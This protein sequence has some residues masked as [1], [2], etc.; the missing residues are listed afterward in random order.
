M[1]VL[2]VVEGTSKSST[3]PPMDTGSAATL[4]DM[5]TWARKSPIMGTHDALPTEATVGV[6]VLVKVVLLC[7]G[8][9]CEDVESQ[10]TGEVGGDAL[11]AHGV[12]GTVEAGR[13]RRDPRLAG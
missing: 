8:C 13:E 10:G 3:I 12:S 2:T 7:R 9:G 1:A 6:S 4:K 11:G 5:S